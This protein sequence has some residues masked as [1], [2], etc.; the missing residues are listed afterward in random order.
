VLVDDGSDQP[1]RSLPESAAAGVRSARLEDQ[2]AAGPVS[3]RRRTA[4]AAA[5]GDFIM[6][7]DDDNIAEPNG[8]DVRTRSRRQARTS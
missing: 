5:T 2:P 3:R 6:F 7:M 8:I 4:I 1:Q